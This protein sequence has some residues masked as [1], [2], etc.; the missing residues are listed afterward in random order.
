MA[1]KRREFL[2]GIGAATTAAI[3]VPYALGSAAADSSVEI[4]LNE[5][6]G[7]VNP[8]IYSH[9]VEH[10]GGVV[11]DGIW[12][13]EKSKI[14]N[15]GGIRKSLVDSLAK[16]KPGVIRYPG[17]CFADQY[18]WRDGIGPRDKRPSRVNF[19]ADTTYKAPKSYQ[20]VQTGP[21]KYEPNWF[22]T[23]EFIKLCRLTG[24]QPYLAANLRSFG[25]GDFMQWLEYCN[26]PAGQTTLS[27]QRVANGNK[28]AFNVSFWGVGNESWGCGGE[29]TP[30]EYA[31]E[32]RR[33][34]AWLPTYGTKLQLIGAGP[35]GG[36]L[37]WTRKFFTK[38][39]EKGMGQLNRMY[40]WALHYYCHTTGKGD[41]SVYD[42]NEWYDLLARSD[43][44]DSLVR[45]HWQVMGEIDREHK[46][47]LVVD[48]WGAWH[49]QDAD[50]PAAY[51]YAY[52]GTLRDALI[53]GINLDTFQRHADKVVM[54][55]PAQ[56]VNTIHSLFHT[57]EDK[58]IETPNYHVFEMYM[59]H[60]GATAVRTEFVSPEV[61]FSRF[62]AQ[63]KESKHEFWG[64]QGSASVNGKTVTLTA[65]NPDAKSPRETEINLR[66]ATI[67]GAKARVLSSTDIRAKNTFANPNGLVPRD[68]A[69]TIGT[70]GRLVYRFAPASVTRLTLQI[71]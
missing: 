64:L 36:D 46:V 52:A 16:L 65:V 66:G 34:S 62:D 25:V 39:T 43:R 38:L 8:N 58:F 56:L 6:I 54:A 26:A 37:G 1:M 30:E 4:L 22:G 71:A 27:N 48:E 59:P 61:S 69:V 33:Y 67:T 17:G 23:D 7:T 11:Y 42:E 55:N 28:D 18:D 53:S 15:I 41:A 40:G 32:Y 9:F 19:W 21:Q 14:P 31:T 44:M 3:A 24:A 63:R 50:M 13:G 68:E 12:V 60:A 45:E 35:N 2:K 5:P 57:Y 70:G 29:F 20:D 47:K 10:L 51:L 49:W